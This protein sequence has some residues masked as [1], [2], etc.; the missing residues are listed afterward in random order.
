[1]RT[2]EFE[3]EIGLRREISQLPERVA[4]LLDIQLRA[5]LYRDKVLREFRE[6]E[7]ENDL[8]R[9]QLAHEEATR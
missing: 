7:Q 3:R 2:D 5:E 4:G 1:M 8:L 6:L 9:W